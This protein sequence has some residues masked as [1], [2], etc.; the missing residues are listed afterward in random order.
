[1]TR[2]F[3]PALALALVAS[4][5]ANGCSF[6]MVK[7]PKSGSQQSPD[8]PQCTVSSRPVVGDG[9][10]FFAANTIGVLLLIAGLVE[11]LD[12]DGEPLVLGFFAAALAS[13][14]FGVSAA[15]GIY[16]TNRCREA[17]KVWR[18]LHEGRGKSSPRD[19]ATPGTEAGT[20]R[21]SEPACD[22]GLTCASGYCVHL[23]TGAPPAPPV[24]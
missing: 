24:Q 1:M 18:A 19:G 6:A 13:A 12:G 2:R 15:Y 22:P 9:V 7:G 14:P 21:T 3:D 4:L 16:Q 11:E 8:P 5:T 20:C 17:R 10:A 23:P